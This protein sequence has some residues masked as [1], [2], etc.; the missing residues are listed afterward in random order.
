MAGSRA[1]ILGHEEI[2][3]MEVCIEINKDGEAESLT[4]WSAVPTLDHLTEI[5]CKQK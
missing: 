5:L 4:P 2:L 1:A 3:G